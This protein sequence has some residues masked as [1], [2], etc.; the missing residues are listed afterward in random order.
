MGE[1]LSTTPHLT[2][3]LCLWF[4]VFSFVGVVDYINFRQ[5]FNEMKF[6]DFFFSI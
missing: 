2:T 3:W 4:V 1:E 6:F 5:S